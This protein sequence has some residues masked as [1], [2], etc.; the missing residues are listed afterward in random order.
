MANGIKRI[1]ESGIRSIVSESLKRA[2]NEIEVGID[3]SKI[4][5]EDLRAGYRDLR[6]H[7]DRVTNF[8]SV[9]K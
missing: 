4:P 8:T 9:N 3:I 2:L 1:T 6:L 7:I 5:I